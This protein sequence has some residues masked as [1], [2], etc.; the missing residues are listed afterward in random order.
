MA[1]FKKWHTRKPPP[2][3]SVTKIVAV[4]C[5]IVGVP[6][7]SIGID[8][9][10]SDGVGAILA[11]GILLGFGV[12]YFTHPSIVRLAK[13]L[14]RATKR[15]FKEK[16]FTPFALGLIGT[17]LIF[18]L[19]CFLTGR[20]D[21]EDNLFLFVIWRIFN[22]FGQWAVVIGVGYFLFKLLLIGISKIAEAAK[23]GVAKAPAPAQDPTPPPDDIET[24]LQRLEGLKEKGLL[25]DA[26]DQAKREEILGEV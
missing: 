3:P 1:T 25:T 5:I 24:R 14:I 2:P 21:L 9:L 22:T 15:L 20:P 17:G 12:L 8:V 13:R 6:T 19:I 23:T 16:G 7:F 4:L 26:E 10:N 18:Y 11:G